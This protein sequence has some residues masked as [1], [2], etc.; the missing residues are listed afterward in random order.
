VKSVAPKFT[1]GKYLGRPVKAIVE[2]DPGYVV[3]AYSN[4]KGHGGITDE[5]YSAAKLA[6]EHN[7]GD[8]DYPEDYDNS[9]AYSGF[10]DAHW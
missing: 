6:I 2:S 1:F 8:D 5:L 10:F 3:W 9:L 4:V 7:D